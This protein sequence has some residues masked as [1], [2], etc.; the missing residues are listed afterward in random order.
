MPPPQQQAPPPPTKP[1]ST[2]LMLSQPGI[3]RDGSVLSRKCYTD[4]EWMRFYQRRPHKMRGF[5]QLVSNLQGNARALGIFNNQGLSYVHAGT[6]AGLFRMSITVATG[7]ASTMQSRTPAG[8]I[9]TANTNWQLDTVYNS[10]GATTSIFAHPSDNVADISQDADTAVY[11]GD[12]LT[13]DP[14]QPIP[15]GITSSGGICAVNPYLFLYGH[16]G[17]VQ[18][19]VPGSPLD[20]ANTGSGSSRPTATKI[21]RGLPLRGQAGPAIIL[22]SL[23]S[24]ITG[25]FVGTPTWFQFT[26]V[27]TNGSILSS[28]GVIEHNGIYY[29]ATTSG[30][31]MFNGVMRDIPN[32]FNKQWFLDNL[33]MAQRQKVFA[34]KVP[35]WNE[36]WWCFP[37]GS[38]TEPTHAVVLNMSDPSAPFW[39]DTILPNGGRTAGYYNVVYNYPLMTGVNGGMGSSVWQHEFGLDEVSGMPQQSLAI[40]SRFRTHEFSAVAP[41]TLGDVGVDR[42]VAYSY[43]EP[44]FEQVKDLTFR[45]WQRPNAKAV[46]VSSEDI[47]VPAVPADTNDQLVKF[48]KTG[49][50]TAFEIESN[51]AG[52]DYFAGAPLVH[53]KPSDGRREG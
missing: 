31:S 35:R 39:Y 8:L 50:L 22:W 10:V 2:Q 38:A 23:D 18:W 40:K 42:S 14:L 53:F 3:I 13:T 36:I 34:F 32:D 15:L 11:Y 5:K 45:L 24:L 1:D 12:V 47:N 20:F 46:S 25:Q 41:P 30:F 48:K 16:D 26:S 28:N 29:W 6:D 52:G 21:V 51:T 9:T 27:T 33:N 17:I 44:D 4:G 7:A 49:R 19:S 43:M 37:Y